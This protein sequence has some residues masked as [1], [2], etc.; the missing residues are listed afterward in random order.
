MSLGIGSSSWPR[1]VTS[2]WQ[3][4]AASLS[5]EGA[6]EESEGS[7]L[8]A[9]CALPM[10]ATQSRASSLPWEAQKTPR[11]QGFLW[12]Q[13]TEMVDS[14]SKA[15]AYC[16]RCTS[17]VQGLARSPSFPMEGSPQEHVPDASQGSALQPAPREPHL[18]H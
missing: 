16:K 3:R 1:S 9:P 15:G 12:G 18:L 8:Q 13:V 11:A 7:G 17:G 4:C 10:G 14:R 2:A 5:G 6:Q